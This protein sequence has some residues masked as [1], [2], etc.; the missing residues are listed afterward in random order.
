MALKGGEGRDSEVVIPGEDEFEGVAS[1]VVRLIWT[2][3]PRRE[4]RRRRREGEFR[5]VFGC[6]VEV[7]E[8]EVGH[9]LG[10]GRDGPDEDS[11]R[12]IRRSGEVEMPEGGEV[13]SKREREGRDGRPGE[14]EGA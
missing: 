4:G 11:P 5:E 2:R 1:A 10:K 14:V 8:I 3:R 6:Q 12:E 9:R 13:L 7:R